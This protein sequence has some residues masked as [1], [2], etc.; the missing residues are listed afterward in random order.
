[1]VTQ[2]QLDLVSNAVCL[3]LVLIMNFS[4]FQYLLI[5]FYRRR[6]EVRVTL[7]LAIAFLSFASLVPFAYPNEELIR[8][9]NDISETCSVLTFL[10][11]IGILTRDVNKKMKVRSL[12][13]LSLLGDLLVLVGIVVLCCNVVDIAAPVVEMD[14][15]EDLDESLEGVSLV[16][17]FGFRFYFLAMAKGVWRVLQTQKAEIGYYLLFVTHECPFMILGHVTGLNYEHFQGMW[18]RMTIVLC[19]WSTIKS[20]L[21]SSMGSKTT[22]QNFSSARP[23]GSQAP[24]P[25]IES[26]FSKPKTNSP[27]AV[28]P[29]FVMAYSDRELA[30]D[31]NDISE[32]CSMMTFLIQSGILERDAS[33]KVKL[34]SINILG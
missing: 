19:L 26:T 29:I 20:K 17:I 13:L 25:K 9:L 8:D 5:M 21:L 12:A 23:I 4:L 24:G 31:L 34:Q 32:T 10:I 16:F 1:M 33:K 18:M 15:I 11:Q 14:V 22:R 28:V 3:P 6:Q 30:R 27:F 7:L 2:A